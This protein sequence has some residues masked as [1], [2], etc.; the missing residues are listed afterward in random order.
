MSRGYLWQNLRFEIEQMFAELGDIHASDVK[1]MMRMHGYKF[2][3]R[4]QERLLAIEDWL[5]EKELPLWIRDGLARIKRKERQEDVKR[6]SSDYAHTTW[7]GQR[8]DWKKTVKTKQAAGVCS[9]PRCSLIAVG[10]VVYC[11]AH[12]ARLAG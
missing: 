8:V 9:W 5:D 4:K 11:E 6:R 2:S 7:H 1:A 12:L 10:G 3:A